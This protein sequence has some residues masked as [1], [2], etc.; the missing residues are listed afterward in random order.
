MDALQI[1]RLILDGSVEK[2]PRGFWKRT[3]AKQD[4][5]ILT[6]YLIE[7]ILM[8]SDEELKEKLRFIVLKEYKLSGMVEKVFNYSIFNLVNNAYPDKFRPWELS[9]V[10]NNYW[11]ENTCMEA[12]KWLFEEKLKWSIDEIKNNLTG[13]IFIENKLN[14]MFSKIFNGS[15]YEVVNFVYPNQIKPWELKQVPN[16]YWNSNT[17]KEAIDWLLEQKLHQEK[18][19]KITRKVFVENRLDGMIQKM[20]SGSVKRANVNINV[21]RE[22]ESQIKEFKNN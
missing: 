18:V 17:T 22:A 9:K 13:E 11:N 16:N 19:K 1:Y 3:E 20:F 8:W 5:A 10:E 6:R 2:F 12:L 21:D 14:G 15:P 7:E 4:A